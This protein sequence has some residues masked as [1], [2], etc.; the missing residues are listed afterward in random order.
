MG[1]FPKYV[2]DVKVVI[3]YVLV[4]IAVSPVSSIEIGGILRREFGIG[5]KDYWDVKR[6]IMLELRRICYVDEDFYL[7]RNG[8]ANFYINKEQYD[9]YRNR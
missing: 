7:E 4:E 5:G 9:R 8:A 6:E 1:V 3:R 2:K